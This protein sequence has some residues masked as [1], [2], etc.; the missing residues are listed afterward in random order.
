MSTRPVAFMNRTIEVTGSTS[1][2]ENVW[3]VKDTYILFIFKM[4]LKRLLMQGLCSQL[5]D[6]LLKVLQK[7]ITYHAVTNATANVEYPGPNH[8]GLTLSYVLVKVYQ[9]SQSIGIFQN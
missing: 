2:W 7:Q 1:R 5:G 4:R 8:E 9:V 3:M 6:R